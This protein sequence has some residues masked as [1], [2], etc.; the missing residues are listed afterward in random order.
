[1]GITGKSRR[2]ANLRSLPLIADKNSPVLVISGRA[3][4]GVKR[5][6]KDK[7]PSDNMDSEAGGVESQR[8]AQA[9]FAFLSK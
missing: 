8:N 6:R 5:D 7:F 3:G 1:M 2:P 9:F 4:R